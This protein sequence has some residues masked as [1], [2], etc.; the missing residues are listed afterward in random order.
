[1]HNVNARMQPRDPWANWNN[2][3]RSDNWKWKIENQ[4]FNYLYYKVNSNCWS[5]Y[6]RQKLWLNSHLHIAYSER[7]LNLPR[8]A[9]A[10]R[11]IIGGILARLPECV[12]RCS[13]IIG[14]GW[15]LEG[16][17]KTFV[18]TAMMV[19]RLAGTLAVW[20]V[21]VVIGRSCRTT[22]TTTTASTISEGHSGATVHELTGET[23]LRWL[24]RLSTQAA[25]RRR[26]G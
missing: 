2:W 26:T 6:S 13:V 7:K 14:Y 8:V 15:R 25:I 17:W 10:R 23:T 9:P 16:K 3:N 5:R 1:M 4:Q 22:S 11:W 21:I 12:L 24:L 19:M 20:A 18:Q